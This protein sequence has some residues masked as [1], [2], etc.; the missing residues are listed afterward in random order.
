MSIGLINLLKLCFTLTF[1]PPKHYDSI[2]YLKGILN[3]IKE[4]AQSYADEFHR[5]QGEL[6]PEDKMQTGRII[7]ITA[8]RFS[9]G[10]TTT[11]LALAATIAANARH[12]QG[13]I[14][15]EANLRDPS[16]HRFC[17]FES[18]GSL[19]R[20]MGQGDDVWPHIQTV[21]ALGVAVLPAGLM[22]DAVPSG[23]KLETTL[24][25]IGKTLEMLRGRY[26]YILVD[27]PPVI[28]FRDSNV[29]ATMTD[30]ILFVV[31]AEVTRSQ[32]V[33]FSLKRLSAVQGKIL[34][35]VLNKRQ[36]HIPQWLYRYL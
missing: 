35:L 23:G 16:V 24:N 20:V 4:L 31:E 27:S 34:G 13:V 11:T 7:Q 2:K 6:F 10:V 8:S 30:G 33:D 29:I 14:V 12:E 26:R 22:S 9:E 36:F 28:P 25:G 21:E 19:A 17:S 18:G 3:M 15:V 32:V 5:L 1:Q